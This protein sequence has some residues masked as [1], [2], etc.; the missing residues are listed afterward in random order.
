VLGVTLGDVPVLVELVGSGLSP[1]L[2]VPDDEADVVE[3]SDGVVVDESLGVVVSLGVLVSVGVGPGES[4]SDAEE[5]LA[6]AVLLVVK[7][8]GLAPVPA[9]A[10]FDDVRAVEVVGTEAQVEL[11]S[12]IDACAKELTSSTATPNS[13]RPM[14]TPSAAGLRSSA[15]TVHPHFNEPV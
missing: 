4:S 2:S 7:V 8:V 6:D 3:G 14:A 11:E 10:V 12:A 9:T 5:S 1:E 13:A 15:L